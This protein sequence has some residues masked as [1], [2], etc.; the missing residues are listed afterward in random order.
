MEA[1]LVAEQVQPQL[2]PQALEALPPVTAAAVAFLQQI[3]LAAQVALH[4]FGKTVILLRMPVREVVAVVAQPAQLLLPQ[5]GYTAL[6][7]EVL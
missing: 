5:Q 4:S 1:V 3:L 6:E 7:R 2:L